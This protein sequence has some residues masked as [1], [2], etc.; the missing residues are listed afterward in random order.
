VKDDEKKPSNL[1]RAGRR[2]EREFFYKNSI[3]FLPAVIESS[4]QSAELLGVF[5]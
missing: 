3:P 4:S 5:F 2:E 1:L